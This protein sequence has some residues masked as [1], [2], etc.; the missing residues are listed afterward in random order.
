MACI[1]AAGQRKINYLVKMYTYGYVS[2]FTSNGK[3]KKHK[4]FVVR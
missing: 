2:A 4:D 3:I 1:Q